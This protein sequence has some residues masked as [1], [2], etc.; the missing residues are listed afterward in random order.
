MNKQRLE[1]EYVLRSN[2]ENIIWNTIGTASGLQKWIADEVTGEVSGEGA[3]LTFTWGDIY[4][5]HETR[6]ATILKCVKNKYIRMRWDDELTPEAFLEMRI[7][8]SELTNDY[9]LSVIDYANPEDLDSLRDIW[10][11]NFEELHRNTGL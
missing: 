8:K 9:V 5:H 1:L 7:S 11:Q 4:K 3:K 6:T 10:D 2:S